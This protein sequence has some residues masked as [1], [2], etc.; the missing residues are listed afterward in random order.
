MWMALTPAASKT[1]FERS[2]TPDENGSTPIRKQPS[3]PYA[4]RKSR[5]QWK[6]DV[7]AS[8][9]IGD[10]L[11]VEPVAEVLDLAAV[12]AEAVA[13]VVDAV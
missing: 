5:F 6:S 12:V 11:P 9:R 8:L 10:D 1:G 2:S 13:V 4:T 7:L 3:S